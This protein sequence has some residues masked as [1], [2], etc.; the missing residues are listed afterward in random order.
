MVQAD[1]VPLPIRACWLSWIA[2]RSS[3]Q[4]EVARHI[5]L[6]QLRELSWPAAVELVDD[7]A[8]SGEQRFSTVVVTPAIAGWTLVVGAWCGLP[9]LNRTEPTT[10]LCRALSADFGQA[11]AYF[12]SEQGDGAAW[13]YAD[14]GEVHRR[15]ISE[16][17]ELALGEPF[18]PERRMLDSLGIAGRPE[19]LDPEDDR[20]GELGYAF[21]EYSPTV[22]AAAWSIDPTTI[23]ATTTTI[24]T[25][26]LA[27]PPM[28]GDTAAEYNNEPADRCGPAAPGELTRSGM[29]DFGRGLRQIRIKEVARSV[30]APASIVPAM[31][32]AG[33]SEQQPPT[34]DDEFRFW[35]LLE[36]AWS[37]VDDAVNVTRLSMAS[38]P[39]DSDREAD[40]AILDEATNDFLEALAKLCRGMSSRELTDLDRVLERKLYDIDRAD[41]Q[42]V[43]DGSDDGFLYARGLIVALGRD[44]Y[45]AV[46]A[47]PRMAIFEGE[48]EAMCYFFAHLHDE[49][50]GAWPAT[51]SGISRESCSNSAGWSSPEVNREVAMARARRKVTEQ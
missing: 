17:P 21:G 39:A 4:L 9:Y 19:D 29:S 25:P 31:T 2:V 51:G 12:H 50:Y 41:I 47:N 42:A 7:V 40:L 16:F 27:I 22:V 38:Q 26:I 8:H 24:G 36:Q 14:E 32:T 5:G 10:D 43:T 46:A 28:A 6:A 48:F 33:P 35:S 3:D 49:R 20:L 34:T 18:G 15:W 11:Q 13:L 45:A 1:D 23:R 37:R 30:S 44:Y